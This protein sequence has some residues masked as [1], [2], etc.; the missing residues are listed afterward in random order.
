MFKLYYTAS[1]KPKVVMQTV[2]NLINPPPPKKKKIYIYIYI[3]CNTPLPYHSSTVSSWTY[4][5][6]LL[7]LPMPTYILQSMKT[8]DMISCHSKVQTSKPFY[9]LTPMSDQDWISPYYFKPTSSKQVMRVKKD[10]YQLG[11]YQLIQYQILQKNTKRVIWQTVRR[12]ANEILGVKGLIPESDEHLI[13]PF[14]ITPQSNIKVMTIKEM[15][16]NWRTSWFS[17]KFSLPAH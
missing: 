14:N 1:P 6:L 17:N 11:D 5:L 9:P 10:L 15:I 12:I 8:V 2:A 16:I 13:S 7:S 3:S 4:P